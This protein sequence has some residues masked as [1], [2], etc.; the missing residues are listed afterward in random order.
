MINPK[1][2]FL[3]KDGVFTHILQRGTGRRGQFFSLNLS[4]NN[5]V[6]SLKFDKSKKYE[7]SRLSIKQSTGPGVLLPNVEGKKL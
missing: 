7:I 1:V 2:S 6:D 3:K 5:K 4:E